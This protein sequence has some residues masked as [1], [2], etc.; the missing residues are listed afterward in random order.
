M[1]TQ[2]KAAWRENFSVHSRVEGRRIGVCT[3]AARGGSHA[4]KER[5]NWFFDADDD[6][7]DD[8]DD[9]DDDDEF[10]NVYIAIPALL[11]EPAAGSQCF[12]GSSSRS[13]ELFS[14][15]I[16]SAA[17]SW[18]KRGGAA[19]RAKERFVRGLPTLL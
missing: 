12:H 1:S 13:K 19:E 7:D 6:D 5:G 14:R 9:D 18:K 3:N 16:A 11:T 8:A 10:Q 2:E 17:A 4:A 15:A